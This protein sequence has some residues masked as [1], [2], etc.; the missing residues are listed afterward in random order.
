MKIS[1]SVEPYL[2]DKIQLLPQYLDEVQR[3]A[4]TNPDLSLHFDYF[5]N[6]QQALELLQTY[7]H[8]VCTYVHVMGQTVPLGNFAVIS[9]DVREMTSVSDERH[10][11]V[12]DLG[13]EI[14][15]Y[16]TLIKQAS[17]ITI[18]AVKCGKSGQV[19]HPEVLELVPKIRALNPFAV[20]TIDGGVNPS[21][22]EMVKKAGIDIAVVG[23]YAVK[24]YENGVFQE[25]VN[26]LLRV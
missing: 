26:R 9:A 18:M 6:N 25:S 14:A 11:I 21:N 23:S 3:L 10:G 2:G 15:G 13:C 16:E 1:I 19:F 4:I 20:L 7:A 8:N 24:S 5:Q 12:I 17:Y 22:I